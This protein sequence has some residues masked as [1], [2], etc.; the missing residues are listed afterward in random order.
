M[1]HLTQLNAELIVTEVMF[2]ILHTLH[3]A[4]HHA[5]YAH[6]SECLSSAPMKQT[7]QFCPRRDWV[8]MY[9]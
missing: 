1:F 5:R 8:K 9:M 6:L 3:H 7:Q 4:T 2:F